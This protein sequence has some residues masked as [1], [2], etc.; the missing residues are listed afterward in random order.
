M[1]T[2]QTL[3]GFRD[4]LPVEAAK[5]KWLRDKLA[6]ICEQWGFAPIETP[7]M[8]PLELFTGQI[9]EDEK[10]F[11]KFKDQGDRDV[12][13]RYD[14]TVPSCR[15][16]AEYQN[17]L[18][19]PF[20]RYQIQPAFRAEK[21]QKGRYREFIQCDADIYG[22]KTPDA[23]AETIALSLDIYKQ[24]GFKL[25]HKTKP[26]YYYIINYKRKYRFNFRKDILVKNGFDKNKSEKQIMIERKIYRIYDSGSIKF[27]YLR[28]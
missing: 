22:I 2:I 28:N 9:G 23:D 8:E 18:I 17:T 20:K 5:R 16:V 1:N 26:N 7:T 27:Q 4:F 24:L 11:F 14:Q 19:F 25:I 6:A 3:K 10:L 12:A 15:V 13:L 21:P